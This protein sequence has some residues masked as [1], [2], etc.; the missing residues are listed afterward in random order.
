MSEIS[1]FI[2][3]V[4]DIFHYYEEMDVVRVAFSDDEDKFPLS[5]MMIDAEKRI[6]IKELKFVKWVKVCYILLKIQFNWKFYKET[7]TAVI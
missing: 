4:I 3:D 6:G 5:A 2:D 7:F 1:R